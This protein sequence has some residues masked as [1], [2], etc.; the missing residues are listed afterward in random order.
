MTPIRNPQQEKARNSLVLSIV[1]FLVALS[2]TVIEM[3]MEDEGLIVVLCGIA[4]VL[5]S[6]FAAAQ[7][8]REAKEYDRT[9]RGKNNILHW[10]P[11]N[12]EWETYFT[13]LPSK[14]TTWGFRRK[15]QMLLR[16]P[17]REIFVSSEGILI[18]THYTSFKSIGKKFEWM[19][20]VREPAP[21][22]DFCYKEKGRYQYY[23]YHVFLPVPMSKINEAE[24]I[25]ERFQDG[26]PKIT[27]AQEKE[28]LLDEAATSA[29][30]F[31]TSSQQESR[32]SFT[33]PAA[34]SFLHKNQQYH[35]KKY[36]SRA[37]KSEYAQTD[38]IQY[39]AP[40]RSTFRLLL[41]LLAFGALAGCGYVLYQNHRA[42][43]ESLF[44]LKGH[45]AYIDRLLFSSDGK[46]LG[47]ITFSTSDKDR[48]PEIS[49]AKLDTRTVDWRPML[50][51]TQMSIAALTPDLEHLV[52]I[53]PYW[54]NSFAIHFFS[55]DRDVF[56]FVHYPRSLLVETM[57]ITKALLS[58]SGKYAA[59]IG[60]DIFLWNAYAI[61][62]I[63]SLVLRRGGM[64]YDIA[65]TSNDE[66]LVARDSAHYLLIEEF[67]SRIVRQWFTKNQSDGISKDAR[68]LFNA[69]ATFALLVDAE[70]I[71]VFEI[72]T[73]TTTAT[74]PIQATRYKN[75]G[76]SPDGRF[77]LGRIDARNVRLI[78]ATQSKT[79]EVMDDEYATCIFSPDGKR[80]A[81]LRSADA[82]VEIIDLPSMRPMRVIKHVDGLFTID[83]SV[84]AAAFSPDGK[85]L[86]TAN[87]TIRLWNVQE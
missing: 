38:A 82:T 46:S 23:Y 85:S 31:Q 61:R 22:L 39:S 33:P 81:L 36:S 65:F 29:R 7:F 57:S 84:S 35:T 54:K 70:S 52:T 59:A 67:P 8:T 87:E 58:P 62:T 5:G 12:E 14:M 9:L 72:G 10:T 74:L 25:A 63:D 13:H 1:F 32:P 73:T 76:L 48:R 68:I 4:G 40:S 50:L 64:L 37:S 79:I 53:H 86:A 47:A 41:I 16:D 71:R 51:E 6:L 15:I 66:L 20:L 69:Q 49:I 43:K 75:F 34:R 24:K 28:I 3:D 80:C 27:P 55:P 2:P 26:L 56:S 77:L 78:D 60:T 30:E 44:T 45:K 11:S 17:H 19:Q 42:M 18:G 83:P 21:M